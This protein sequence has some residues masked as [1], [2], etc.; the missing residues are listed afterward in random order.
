M[1]MTP[2]MHR[3]LFLV[4]HLHGLHEI[5]VDFLGSLM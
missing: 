4:G 2:E 1:L 3:L 5:D